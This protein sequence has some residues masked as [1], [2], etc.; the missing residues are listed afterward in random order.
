MAASGPTETKPTFATVSRLGPTQQVQNQLLA[1]IASNEYP[2]GS[3]M[4]SERVLCELFG[5][6]RVSI[7]EALAGLAA[8]GL[9]EIQQGRGA[10]VRPRVVDEYAGPFGLY[11]ERHRDELAEL[12]RVRGA[13]DGLAAS[14][15]A[16]HATPDSRIDLQRAYDNFKKAVDNGATPQELTELDVKFHETIAESGHGTLLPSLLNELNNLLIE[17][18]HILF[19]RA[20]QPQRSVSDHTSIL[21]AILD[22]DSV[23]AQ[24][25]ASRHVEK[26]WSWVK[27]FHSSKLG[28]ARK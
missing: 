17:S 27:E 23:K 2:P 14:E 13:L 9:I 1:A 3:L 19:A 24:Q 20:G 26:M 21:K 5:V 11:I 15:A 25:R 28:A 7:R 18:R 10:F 4:P 22:G 6:S 16:S 12:L 8:T